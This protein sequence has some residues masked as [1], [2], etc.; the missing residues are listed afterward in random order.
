MARVD[1]RR[2]LL[3]GVYDNY[4][5]AADDWMVFFTANTFLSLCFEQTEH[6]TKFAITI[7][8]EDVSILRVTW[9][10]FTF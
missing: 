7:S 4:D 3:G 9:D 8:V 1:N 10:A 5:G 2:P 6:I